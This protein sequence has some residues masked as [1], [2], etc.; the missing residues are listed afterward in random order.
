MLT[1]MEYHLECI[2]STKRSRSF[3]AG[4]PVAAIAI[5]GGKRADTINAG[6]VNGTIPVGVRIDG[7][8]GDDAITTGA[9]NDTINAGNGN[10]VVNA[11]DG[12]NVVRG[13]NG[14]DTI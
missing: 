13:G 9:E 6:L 14:N 11:G 8:K 1:P 5:V 3:P 10:D 12:N 7:L 4:P 2:F